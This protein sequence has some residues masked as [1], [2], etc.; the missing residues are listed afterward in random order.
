MG[1]WKQIKNVIWFRDKIFFEMPEGFQLKETHPDLLAL[2]EYVLLKPWEKGI[3]QGHKFSRKQ[4][5]KIGLAF[6]T[7]KDSTAAKFLLPDD[8]VLGYNERKSDLSRDLNQ[9]NAYATLSKIRINEPDRK[10][11]NIATNQE[12]VRMN[13]NLHL[14]YS[15]DFCVLIPC[16]LMADWYNLGFIATG[17]ILESAYMWKGKY[18]REFSD[19]SYTNHYYDL[20]LKAGLELVFPVAG[21]AE[22]LTYKIVGETYLKDLSQSC[23]RGEYGTVCKKCAKCFRNGEAEYPLSR[24]IINSINNHK[25][26]AS[27][28][29]RLMKN[30]EWYGQQPIDVSFLEKGYYPPY[31]KHCGPFAQTIKGNLSKFNIYAMDSQSISN[32]E[33]FKEYPNL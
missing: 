8:T 29:Y 18:F 27:T 16:I 12:E 26:W 10:I 15:T 19:I 25:L 30:N 32:L 14:G 22:V 21:V 5:N 23:L 24:E 17:T 20:F 31:L 28:A 13:H 3:L 11:F 9:S 4:G 1:D 2:C 33:N 7:G 6:S